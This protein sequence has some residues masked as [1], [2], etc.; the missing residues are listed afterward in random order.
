MIRFVCLI[1]AALLK[2]CGDDEF[3]RNGYLILI[4]SDTERVSVLSSSCISSF[5]QPGSDKC[6]NRSLPYGHPCSRA[7]KLDV[8]KSKLF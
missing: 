2:N 5:I 8:C 3:L 1:L 4:S 7:K 6:F